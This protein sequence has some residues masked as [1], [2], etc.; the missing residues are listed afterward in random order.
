MAQMHDHLSAQFSSIIASFTYKWGFV[1][2]RTAYADDEAT[3]LIHGAD[4]EVEDHTD[5]TALDLA[6]YY[7][8]SNVIKILAD[9]PISAPPP[10]DDESYNSDEEDED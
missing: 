9:M 1:V 7:R 8:H 5:H 6:I 2:V 4:H 10:T 3:L